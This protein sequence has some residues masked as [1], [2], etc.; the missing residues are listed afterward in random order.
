[1]ILKLHDFKL[2]AAKRMSFARLVARLAAV[3]VTVV[4]IAASCVS[5]T[6]EDAADSSDGS[7]VAPGVTDTDTVDTTS[8]SDG[9]ADVVPVEDA[10]DEQSELS[11]AGD[12][13]AVAMLI[14]A[15]R[16]SPEGMLA[17]S[18][19]E[20][21][22][23][24]YRSELFMELDGVSELL[25][26][27]ERASDGSVAVLATP[28]ANGLNDAS[29][30]VLDVDAASAMGLDD[31]VGA[32]DATSGLELRYVDG[33]VY[34]KWPK[35]RLSAEVVDAIESANG[36]SLDD[37]EHVWQIL[38]NNEAYIDEMLAEEGF[39]ADIRN[40]LGMCGA[41]DTAAG[42]VASAPDATGGVVSEVAVSSVGGLQASLTSCDPL[43]A[44]EDMVQFAGG[45]SIVSDN[46]QIRGVPTTQVNFRLDL[47]DVMNFAM[48]MMS[49]SVSNSADG[50]DSTESAED[51]LGTDNT[52]MEDFL[53]M[54]DGTTED[55]SIDP[56]AEMLGGLSFVVD[57]WIDKESL[58]RR[59]S[60][61][62]SDTQD[63]GMF[64]DFDSQMP[65]WHSYVDFYDFNAEVV[66]EAPPA[67]LMIPK[68]ISLA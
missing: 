24:S 60:V 50:A 12:P 10:L 36:V 26:V 22:S 20:M 9:T 33:E 54:G 2:H 17:D 59:M 64:A 43:T 6:E 39:A 32:L 11:I 15:V 19:V 66:V 34:V 37:V 62:Y 31:L 42:G 13:E 49:D 41:L 44:M 52:A 21:L 56:L 7:A 23:R 46:V 51:I 5:G 14:N 8:D 63:T 29:E 57:V 47:A 55:G 58:I 40:L 35:S 65:E 4:L 16:R 38:Y 48:N 1:M 27:L 28:L 25:G 61:R 68:G 3:C 18:A 30:A 53:N 67:N 45:A